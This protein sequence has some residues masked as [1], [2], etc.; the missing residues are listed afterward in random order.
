MKKNLLQIKFAKALYRL[1]ADQQQTEQ[2]FQQL[3]ELAALAADKK[4]V[5]A[6]TALSFAEVDKILEVLK[7]LFGKNLSPAVLNMMTL[8]VANRQVRLLP[9]IARIYQKTYFEAENIKDVLIF[10]SRDLS[11]HESADLSKQLNAKNKVHLNFKVDQD[12]IGGLQIYENGRLTDLS[13]KNQLEYLR[14]ELLG[15]HLV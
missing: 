12:L 2:Y 11:E 10:T 4:L 1:A 8:L 9:D 5:E 7:G 6:L 15:E 14:R 13:L 3:K